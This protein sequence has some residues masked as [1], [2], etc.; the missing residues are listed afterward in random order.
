MGSRRSWNMNFEPNVNMSDPG[1]YELCIKIEAEKLSALDIPLPPSIKAKINSLNIL[2]QIKGTTGIEGNT[3]RE[4][5]IAKTLKAAKKDPDRKFNTEEQEVINADLVLEFIKKDASSNKEGIVTEELI[6]HIHL[7]T[8]QKCDYPENIPGEYRRTIVHAGEYQAPSE[9]K[10]EKLMQAF[11]KLIN[12][13]YAP[14]IRNPVTRAIIAHFY[15]VT[16]HPFRDGNGRTSRALEAYILF[17]GKYNVNNFYSLANFYYKNRAEYVYKLQEARFKYNGNLTEFVKFALK[18]YLYEMEFGRQ[19]MLKFIKLVTYKDFI[20]EQFTAKEINHR[21]F[22]LISH[23][24]EIDIDSPYLLF[25]L[26]PIPLEDFKKRQHPLSIM[27]YENLTD[28]TL[29]RDIDKLKRLSLIFIDE[30]DLLNANIDIMD[31]FT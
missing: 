14:E 12:N 6:R 22:N 15:L 11:I 26:N 18:G 29:Y 23:L 10:I 4:E 25:E 27:L 21:Q 3:L 28:R 2:R 5:E 31:Q 8:T 13:T 17:H 20:L 1:I 7:I 24:T 16:I 9:H 19:E 30:N